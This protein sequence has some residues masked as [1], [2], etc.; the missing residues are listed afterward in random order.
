MIYVLVGVARN[1]NTAAV[2]KSGWLNFRITV[3][4]LK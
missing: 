1:I 4:F 2:N 3:L